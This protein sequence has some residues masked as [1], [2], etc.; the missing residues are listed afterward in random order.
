MPDMVR[1]QVQRED[2]RLQ[3]VNTIQFQGQRIYHSLDNAEIYENEEVIVAQ[4][5][6]R[7]ALPAKFISV[8]VPRFQRTSDIGVD[9]RHSLVW[10]V[11]LGVG[12]ALKMRSS[13][14]VVLTSS[15][16]HLAKSGHT[17]LKTDTKPTHSISL[18]FRFT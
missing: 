17:Y 9:G 13:V 3:P 10:L 12:D 15:C 5:R 16:E 18:S 7:P 2:T 1:I 14:R 8:R 4:L 11:A 6:K